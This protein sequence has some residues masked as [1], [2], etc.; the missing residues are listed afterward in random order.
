M[1]LFRQ[2]LIEKKRK[3]YYCEVEYLESTGTQY[4]D[5]GLDYFADFEVGIQLRDNVSNKALGNAA[6]YCMQRYNASNPY[7]YFS[8]GSGASNSYTSSTPITE[9]HV[10]KWKDNKIYSDDV[11]LTEFT[12]NLNTP[13]RMYL[14][15]AD[16]G[17]KYPNMIYFCKL[18]E[19]NS[20]LLVRDFIPVLDFS[21]KPCMYDKISGKLFYNQN[22]SGDDFSYGREI[23]YVDYLESTGTQYIDTGIVGDLTTELTCEAAIVEA[24]NAS[25]TNIM[26]NN[27]TS[28][29]AITINMSANIANPSPSRIR[30]SNTDNTTV[31][32]AI[33]LNTFYKYNTN[34]DNLTVK[35]TN[36]IVLNTY[37]FNATTAFTTD[38]NILIY[39]LGDTSIQYIG[40]IK[41]SK[42]SIKNSGVLVRDFIPAI[43]S[44]GV[45]FMFD[46]VTHTIYD[47]AG[48]GAFKYPAREVEYIQST[49]TQYIDTGI[50]PTDTYGYRI[51]NTYTAGQGEQCAI[52]CMDAGNRFVGIYTSGSANAVSGAW[53]DYVGFLPSYTWTT[54]TILDVKCNYKNSRKIIIDDTEMK[55][56]SDVHITDTISNTIYIGAR[57]YGSNITKMQGK[58]Y[59]AEITN[60]T[61]TVADFI[62]VLQDGQAGMLD[63]V[64]KVFYPNAG[65]GTFSTG[66]IV[67]SRWF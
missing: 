55:D 44:D 58:I 39:K 12:K 22:T 26:G 5:T 59:S 16:G 57:H 36:N 1:S 42:A 10:M 45:G 30:F 50:Q 25:V 46:R 54:G 9:Y 17:N 35:D 28:S 52:G 63:K 13:N 56:I 65:T 7:W 2:L 40:K 60:N 3:P 8:T 43:D 24:G 41:V 34:K 21:L 64:N 11:L 23:H 61:D 4:I 15:S 31:A 33:N 14:Y 6:F 32:G 51:K 66:K 47:N 20:G 27:V 48:T 18:W 19:P 49:G 62:P 37:A 38:G 53:G 67:E 29:R